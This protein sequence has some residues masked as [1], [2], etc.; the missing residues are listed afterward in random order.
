VCV[1]VVRATGVGCTN[2][3][4]IASFRLD[5]WEC[6]GVQVDRTAVLGKQGAA[7]SVRVLSVCEDD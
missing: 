2:D 6:G 7:R 4:K 5:C 3:G 1:C